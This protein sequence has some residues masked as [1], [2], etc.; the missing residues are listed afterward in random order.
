MLNPG[1]V[2]RKNIFLNN[3]I[4][5]MGRHLSPRQNCA[6]YHKYMIVRQTYDIAFSNRSRYLC[7]EPSI[8]PTMISFYSI[9][10]IG[11]GNG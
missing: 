7:S 3:M 9:L 2:I 6:G 4:A 8:W 10:C 11:N 1:I 5:V